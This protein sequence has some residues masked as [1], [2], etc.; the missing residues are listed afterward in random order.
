[1]RPYMAACE[2]ILD[3]AVLERLARESGIEFTWVQVA[4]GKTALDGRLGS[5]VA[6]ARSVPFLVLRD[7]D[8]DAPCAPR[9]VERLVPHPTREFRLHVAVRTVEAWFLADANGLAAE[10]GVPPSR[11]PLSPD[12]LPDPRAEVLTLARRSRR[13]RVAQDLLPS[14]PGARIGAGYTARFIRFVASAWDPTRARKRSPSL[15]SLLSHLEH[16]SG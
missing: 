1:M 6:T 15:D 4:G 11:T 16:S 12:D 13:A 3:Q 7:L 9:L 8:A 14:S 10:L 5:F 2:G